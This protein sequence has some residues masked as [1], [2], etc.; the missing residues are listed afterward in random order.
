MRFACLLPPRY[1]CLTLLF[2]T[3]FFSADH[4]IAQ[5]LPDEQIG[6]AAPDS[7]I[8]MFDTSKGSF[9]VKAHRSWSPLAVDRFY[10]LVRLEYF[11]DTSIYRV[12]AGFVAQFGIH[13]QKE[14][15]DAWKKLGIKDEPVKMSNRRGTVSFARGGPETRGTQLFIN[16]KDNENLDTMPVANVVGYPPIGV[17]ESGIE[18][19]DMFNS[20][21]GNAPATKQDSIN[22][23]GRTYLDKQFPGL[24][25][26]KKVRILREY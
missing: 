1:V 12:V 14:V 23:Y 25:V 16:L 26:I 6:K 10:H 21:Y 18:V 15:N 24:D 9:V 11:N 8:V 3:F 22:A 5:Y 17:V 13:N 4:A 2:I 19:V 7:F 20:K